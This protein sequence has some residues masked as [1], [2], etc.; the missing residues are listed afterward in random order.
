VHRESRLEVAG[1]HLA[2]SCAEAAV[3]D[4]D[5]RDVLRDPGRNRPLRL[6]SLDVSEIVVVD[7]RLGRC[8]V[9]VSEVVGSHVHDSKKGAALGNLDAA[10]IVLKLGKGDLW[11][12]SVDCTITSG[13]G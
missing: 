5:A 13:L 2:Q 3:G 9:T 10:E 11:E 6:R 7:G 4:F 1:R 8:C 12:V